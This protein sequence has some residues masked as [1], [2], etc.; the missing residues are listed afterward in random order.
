MKKG[1]GVP[2]CAPEQVEHE[3][4]PAQKAEKIL[5]RT[6]RDLRAGVSQGARKWPRAP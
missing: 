3:A 1:G 5:E 4:D 6:H 2:P